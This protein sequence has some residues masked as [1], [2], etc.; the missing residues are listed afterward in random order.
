MTMQI[1]DLLPW[2]RKGGEVKGAEENP[3]AALQR[4][5]N[6]VFEGFWGRA[7]RPFGAFPALG[8]AA[9]RSDV[10]ETDTGVEITVELPGLDEKDLDVSVT[11]DAVTIKGEKKIER[12][13]EK[14]G[15]YISERSYGSVYRSIPLPAGVDSDKAEANFKNGVLTV[16]L[17]QSAEAKAK[18]KKVTVKTA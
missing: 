8:E 18:V 10:V 9:P 1:K 4:E 16:H 5:M 6:R 17:P 7:E 12:K 14:K 3:I 11:D 2:A 13:E 15:Y